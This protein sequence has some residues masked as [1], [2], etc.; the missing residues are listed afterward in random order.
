MKLADF[1]EEHSDEFLKF[2]RIEHKFN[3]RPDLHA[4]I[5]LDRLLPGTDDMVSGASHDEIYLGIDVD[6]LL[7]VALESDLIDLH[8]CGI[9][10]S[11]NYGCLYSFV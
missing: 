8:R 1:F 5:L 6:R 3:R 11:R 9:L 4:F 7:E 10:Y 2:D